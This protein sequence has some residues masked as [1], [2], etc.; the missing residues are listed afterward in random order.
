MIDAFHLQHGMGEVHT[1][2]D[3][4][5]SVKQSIIG[6]TF[7]FSPERKGQIHIGLWMKRVLSTINLYLFGFEKEYENRTH[8]PQRTRDPL[9]FIKSLT[10]LNSQSRCNRGVTVSKVL[11]LFTSLKLNKLGMKSGFILTND[12]EFIKAS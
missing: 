7:P 2:T 8:I 10:F 9:L 4:E 6:N 11:T 12:A 3:E 5:R 1:D